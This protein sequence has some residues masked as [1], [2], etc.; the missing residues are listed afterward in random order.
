[1]RYL[2]TG[3]T[4]FLG[5]HLVDHLL[6]R[7]DTVTALVRDVTKARAFWPEGVRVETAELTDRLALEGVLHR[8]GPDRVV[9]LAAQPFPML[10][11]KDPQATFRTNLTGT[12][13]LL[14]AVRAWGGKTR[15]LVAST[16]AIYA[17]PLNATPIAEDGVQ[18][19]ISPYGV[20]KLAA[21]AAAALYGQRYELAVIRARPFFIIGPRKNGDACSDFCR[22]MALAELRNQ[23]TLAVGNVDMVRDLLDYRDARA[24]LLAIL[25]HGRTGEAYNVCSGRGTALHEVLAY[26]KPL[27]RR[28][29]REVLDA[30]LLRP[31]DEPVKVGDPTKLQS[32]GWQ[33]R[34]TVPESLPAVLDYWR[35]RA[36]A[37]LA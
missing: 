21:D 31:V 6:A 20:S 22:R 37:G 35:E 10:S 5:S 32:L 25:E 17:V 15:V 16:S 7:G 30:T 13:A 29:I 2:V 11:W 27:A 12:V 36:G 23:D 1:M 24:G 9:H 19:P 26:L 8:A 3:A 33:A 28:P 14:E 4:G 18:G 34:Y